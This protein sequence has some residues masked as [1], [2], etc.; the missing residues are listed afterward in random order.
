MTN[1]D[2]DEAIVTRLDVII[3]LLMDRR[4]DEDDSLSSGDQLVFL[5]KLHLPSTDAAHIL[6]LNPNQLT[7][8]RRYAKQAKKQ[9]KAG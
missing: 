3:R 7:S 9:E 2:S 5:E 4:K 1:E 8:Y 6:G